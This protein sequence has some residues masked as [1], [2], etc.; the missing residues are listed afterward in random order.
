[1]LLMGE[2]TISTGP[3]SIAM[4]VYQ[5]VIVY[6]IYIIVYRIYIYLRVN[7]NPGLRNPKRLLKK[8]G[9]IDVSYKVTIWRVPPQF[10]KPWF[11]F[12]RS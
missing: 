1:M 10:I 9:S 7:V 12:I 2:S 6:R 11:F 4:L 5:R 8:G 3:F